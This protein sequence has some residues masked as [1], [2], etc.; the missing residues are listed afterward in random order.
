MI[1]DP[2]IPRR[3]PR[4]SIPGATWNMQ[5]AAQRR[6]YRWLPGICV[7]SSPIFRWS[8]STVA[9]CIGPPRE[10]RSLSAQHW[11]PCS[12]RWSRWIHWAPLWTCRPTWSVQAADA[13]RPSFPAVFLS[14][15][16]MAPRV[17]WPE[18]AE[19][20]AGSAARS[21]A[22]RLCLLLS[23]CYSYFPL[24]SKRFL[25]LDL[26]YPT[27]LKARS[28]FKH[29]I[30]HTQP[31]RTFFSFFHLD[32]H[33]EVLGY[34]HLVGNPT[35][36]PIAQNPETPMEIQMEKWKKSWF[37]LQSLIFNL[38][39]WIKIS[40]L[41]SQVIILVNWCE[42][43]V[44]HMGIWSASCCIGSSLSWSFSWVK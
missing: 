37:L 15:E 39:T 30:S 8:W 27:R 6:D 14:W 3:D 5:E 17:R 4:A 22:R 20:F 43:Q 26:I 9:S 11:T 1:R 32:F 23:S 41:R 42:S 44:D 33:L 7:Q 35:Q 24:L 34:R 2:T 28:I 40:D 21:E 10:T 19:L 12:R 13:A 36:T 29:P 18:A 16:T 38:E 25:Y 31:N